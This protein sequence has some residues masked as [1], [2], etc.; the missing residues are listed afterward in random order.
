M[1][2]VA[3]PAICPPL[4]TAPSAV[5]AGDIFTNLASSRLRIYAQNTKHAR[6][7]GGKGQT[8]GNFSTANHFNC[9]SFVRSILFCFYMILRNWFIVFV[10]FR[11]TVNYFTCSGEKEQTVW[12]IRL[13]TC[14][15]WLYIAGVLCLKG[16]EREEGL[17]GYGGWSGSRQG[18]WSLPD[19]CSSNSQNSTDYLSRPGL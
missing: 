17:D 3:G 7:A 1:M 18:H 15:T 2:W 11:L 9:Q 13:I 14:K 6:A 5:R 19:R 4:A 10:I 12:F 8:G 16:R